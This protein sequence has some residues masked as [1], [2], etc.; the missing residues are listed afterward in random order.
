MHL[1]LLNY[2]PHLTICHL[3]IVDTDYTRGAGINYNWTPEQTAVV[4]SLCKVKASA[5]VILRE[6]QEKDLHSGGVYLHLRQ[7]NTKKNYLWQMQVMDQLTM[8]DTT[9][10]RHA[11]EEKAAIP[12]DNHEPYIAYYNIKDDV[13]GIRPRFTIIWSTRHL[14]VRMNQQFHQDNATYKL[15][16]EGCPIFT[17][18]ISTSTGRHFMTHIALCSHEDTAAWIAQYNLILANNGGI[19]P[20]ILLL[21]MA[22]SFSFSGMN[23]QRIQCDHCT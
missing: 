6:L 5:C 11:C 14:L 2:L 10:L 4:L 7:L 9:D 23:F 16:W 12:E 19:R 8:V 15:V 18:G 21:I 22:F 13:E 1:P 20:G 17:S 3:D